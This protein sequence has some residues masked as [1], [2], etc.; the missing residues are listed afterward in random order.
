MKVSNSTQCIKRAAQLGIVVLIGTACSFG[1][2]VGKPLDNNMD[3]NRGGMSK[4]KQSVKLLNE[5]GMIHIER[6]TQEYSISMVLDASDENIYF[7]MDLPQEEIDEQVKGELAEETKMVEPEPEPEPTPEVEPEPEPEPAAEPEMEPPPQNNQETL[8]SKYVLYAQTY[9]FEK[10][11][12]RA[13]EEVNRAI[14]YSPQS[15]VAHS[16]KGSIYFKLGDKELAK[17]S[18][19]TALKLDGSLDNVKTMLKQMELQDQS[20]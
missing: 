9:F 2:P 1:V 13:L 15:A 16:L 19:E 17:K 5:P 10:K 8:S 12:A 18:W 3:D 20:S 4:R 14:E 6:H 7:V 11:Y